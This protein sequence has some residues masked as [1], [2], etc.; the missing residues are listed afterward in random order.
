MRFNK[1]MVC[2]TVVLAFA[3]AAAAA[4]KGKKSDITFFGDTTIAGTQLKAGDYQVAVEGNVATFYKHGKEVAKSA[5][6]SQDA[7]HKVD[8][9]SVVYAEDGRVLLEL[10]LSGSSSHL[11]LSGSAPSAG[12]SVAGRN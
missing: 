3:M 5:V 8:K 2:A 6:A 1:G 12:G 9:T 7:G 4:P 11:V 10:R